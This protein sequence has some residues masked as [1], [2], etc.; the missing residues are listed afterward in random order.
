MRKQGRNTY[1][2]YVDESDTSPLLNPFTPDFGRRPALLVGRQPLLEDIG[3]SL[4]LGPEDQGFTRLLLGQRGSG[5]T[6]TLAEIREAAAYS[7]MLVLDV[8]AATHGMLERISS[9]IADARERHETTVLSTAG[10]TRRHRWLSG[11]TLGPVGVK[12]EEMPEPLPRWSLGYHLE[13]LSSWAASQ[14]SA[15]LLTVDEMHAGD[16]DELRRL[17]SDVQSIAKVK[18]LPLAFVGAGLPEMAHTVLEDK[19]MTFFHR[20]F[21][22]RM[23]AIA[24]DDAWRCLR[25]TVEES[26][27]VV[28][29]DALR[30]MA[31]AAADGLPY[32]L[33]SIGH[34]AWEL[35][36]S[37]DRPVDRRAAAMAVDL[38]DEDMTEKVVIPMWHDLGE[39]DLSYLKA[40]SEYGGEASPRE[41]A[42]RLLET[43]SRTLAR[44]ERRLAAA[45]HLVRTEKG[46]VKLTGPLTAE[47]IQT[48]AATESEYD[49]SGAD[50]TPHPSTRAMPDRCNAPMP[51][52][53]AK[54]VLS[55]G[56]NGG[57]RS[58]T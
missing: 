5:K 4:S 27:G 17:A 8:D 41:V 14:G 13:T 10:P 38:A 18:G 15:V 51:R 25:L 24:Y 35:S 55:R 19:K 7:G 31:S 2:G 42:Q 36:G 6:T 39:T 34:H 16:R 1:D 54:C 50:P 48:I 9:C 44:S 40:L 26:G 37:P 23:P 22:D 20:C 11:V 52:A 33:Q 29:E 46:T 49:I 43:P 28:H 30:L 47:A 32:K 12:W 45:G 53:K 21:R 57:H 56:H 58:R 3:N